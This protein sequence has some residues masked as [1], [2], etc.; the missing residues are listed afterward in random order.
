[1]NQI[2]KIDEFVDAKL[3][4]YSKT[5]TVFQ[6]SCPLYCFVKVVL[7]RGFLK[8]VNRMHKQ[9]CKRG[10]FIKPIAFFLKFPMENHILVALLQSVTESV[11]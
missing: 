1:M 10:S 2:N 9:F 6:L 4:D 7:S 8:V 3:L 11:T 5:S